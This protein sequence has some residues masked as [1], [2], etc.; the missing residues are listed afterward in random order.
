A[1]SE[2]FSQLLESVTAEERN[3][4]KPANF[5]L[6]AGMGVSALK[7]YARAQ[8]GQEYSDE[9]AVGWKSAWLDSFPEMQ[10]FLKDIDLGLALA[11]EV[12]L[13]LGEFDQATTGRLLGT[14]GESIP[15]PWLGGMARKVLRDP[16]PARNNGKAYSQKELDFFWS[17]LQKLSAKLE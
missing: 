6:P 7:N 15:L 14:A 10:K 3:A 9:D 11:R 2:K 8:F 16:A 4:A 13:T 5:G 17:R 12:N 1:S